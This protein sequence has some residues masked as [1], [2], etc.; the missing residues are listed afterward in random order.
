M[1][2]R[3][4]GPGCETMRGSHRGLGWR[5][6]GVRRKIRIKSCPQNQG[7][8]ET[9]EKEMMNGDKRWK[10]TNIINTSFHEYI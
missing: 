3:E 9:K 2:K 4:D 7:R 10:E 6:E 8:R 5:E 1:E